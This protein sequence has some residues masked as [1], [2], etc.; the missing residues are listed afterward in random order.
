[1]KR[2]AVVAGGLA[3]PWVARADDADTVVVGGVQLPTN[4]PLFIAQER[5]L[6]AREGVKVQLT[7]FTAAASVFTAVVSRDVDVGT[8][9]VTAATYNLAAKGGFKIIGGTT[10]DVAHFPLNGILVSNKAWEAGF[11]K[12]EEMAGKRWGM[13]TAG[14]TFHYDIGMMAKKYGVAL[15]SVALVPLEN[16][17]NI[18]AALGT[19]QVDAALLPPAIVRRMVEAKSARFLAWSGDEV[20]Y[21]QGIVCASPGTIGRK[22]EVLRRFMRAYAAGAAEYHRVF[23]QVDAGGT[24][25]KGDGYGPLLEVIARGA[26]IKP[27]GGGGGDRVHHPGPAAGRGGPATADRVLAGCGAGVAVGRVFGVVRPVAAAGVSGAVPMAGPWAV[28]T[29]GCGAI[30]FAVARRLA[31]NGVCAVLVDRDAAAVPDRVAALRAEFGAGD[32]VVADL[33]EPGAAEGVAAFLRQ[34]G[35]RPD[36]L[37]NGAGLSRGPRLGEVALAD[38]DAVLALNL[39]APMLL[40]QAMLPW[41]RD[42][43]GGR[44]V[45]I[46]SRVWVSGSGPAYT[47]S[48]AGLVGLTRSMAVQLGPLGVTANVV[49]PSFI[50]TPFNAGS[51]H[52]AASRSV[53]VNAR[54]GVLGR[55]GT[56]EDVAGAVAFL[57]S[58]DASFITGEVVHVCGG[59]QLA[60][61][62]GMFDGV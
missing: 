23:N 48:K 62:P 36:V 14:S 52:G 37:V 60:G 38:W 28:V 11:T 35:V 46:G 1:M 10:R 39:T 50:D 58:A 41:W 54:L 27:S 26:N 9:G 55:V 61:R 2:R 34:A 42:G 29:G 16:F 45:N 56:A 24:P 19:G 20:P 17:G 53:E 49:A 15:S 6:F 47:A 22:A 40:T 30:G 7:W 4:A 18:S 25:V 12:L 3:L 44:V 32:G 43:R 8:T 59:A 5:G 13:T 31:R 21:Q 57:A 51:G 33:A